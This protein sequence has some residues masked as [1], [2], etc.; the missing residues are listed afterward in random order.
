MDSQRPSRTAAMNASLTSSSI[1][2]L[3]AWGVLTL[4]VRDRW[5]LAVFQMG[6]FAV[7]AAW[8]VAAMRRPQPLIWNPVIF[9]L[10]LPPLLGV[11]QIFTK[12]TIY[13]W[14]TESAAIS[15]LAH[16]LVVF[17]LIQTAVDDALR[18]KLL[19]G[20]LVFAFGL[21][22]I[23]LLQLF[24][25]EGKVFWLFESGYKDD[26]LGP[27]VYRNNYAQFV[28]LAF[29]LA[30]WRAITDRRR[31]PL[32]IVAAATLF[33]SVVAG[34]S[35]A[36]FLLLLIEAV[37]VL[38]LAWRKEHVTGRLALTLGAQVALLLVVSGA[39][40]GWGTLGTRLT[41]MD[42]LDDLR[43]PLARS[44]LDMIG[45]KP[46]LGFGLGTWPI[47]YPQFALFDNGLYANQAH[48]DW[49]QWAAEGGLPLAAI[50]LAAA[51][52]IGFA[53]VRSVWGIGVVAVLLHATVDYPF[54]QRPAFA[55]LVWA[56]AAITIAEQMSNLSLA[57]L[58]TTMTSKLNTLF[59]ICAL[60]LPLAAQ[61]RQ[62]QTGLGPMSDAGVAN[63]PGQKIGP[64]DLLAI[65]V[66]GAPEF[67]RTVRVGADGLIRLPMVK[68]RLK[69]DGRLPSELEQIV[70]DTLSNEGI[71]VNPM[72]IVTVVEYNSRP[73]SV[74]GAVRRPLT[75][76]SVG[77]ITLLDALARAEGISP[78]AGPY[79]VMTSPGTGDQRLVRR[80]RM[81][82][83][84]DQAK[85]E[86]NYELQGGEE[87]RIP[88]AR[89][90]YVSG[91]VK[92]SGS[93]LVREGQPM[94]VLKALALAEGLL[95]YPQKL[96][97]I[98]RPDE[99]SG[100]KREIPVELAKL[101]QRKSEDVQLMPDDVLYIPEDRG[102]KTTFTVLEKTLGFS[103]ATMSGVL[104][105]RR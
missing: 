18:Q 52:L 29:P 69:V 37:V 63:L 94:T 48:S 33:A 98:Y 66:Y 85:P 75:F 89:R 80:I 35:R 42:P 99:R 92:K 83:L 91:N 70:A 97:Y 87:I 88:E 36:G 22:A 21:S 101:V 58:M 20:F 17:L 34:A 64:N 68:E 71:L 55:S 8:I 76:Q 40:V 4:W 25:S 54:Q 12:R 45:A 78:E 60:S 95:P 65:S 79:I 41:G 7:A 51:A 93:F 72:V 53:A 49:L 24:T 50:L 5:A 6:I 103:L 32:W 62:P 84:L 28:E 74:M 77:R 46:F 73:I 100:E 44:T 23:A 96:A 13:P 67:T 102:R 14:E 56:L 30:L 19:N 3:L 61:T 43:L 57:K 11:V 81:D 26:V 16:L 31:A 9:L 38:A 82:E 10:A 1:A 39:L 105:W 86:L 59:L 15:W 2:L 27:F 90:I 104:I 47:A